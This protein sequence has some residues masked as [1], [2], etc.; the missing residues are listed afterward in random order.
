MERLQG[1]LDES[2]LHEA[3]KLGYTDK[4]QADEIQRLKQEVIT[5]RDIAKG[6]EQAYID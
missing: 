3:V 4:R 5:M 2:E 6:K 1:G